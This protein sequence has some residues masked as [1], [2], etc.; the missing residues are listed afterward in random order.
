MCLHRK[1][2]SFCYLTTLLTTNYMTIP[3]LYNKFLECK[4]ISTDTRKV[5]GGELFFALKGPN[6]NANKFAEQAIEKG[7][8]YAVIDDADFAKSEQYI[9]VED[10]LM[11]LQQLANH[12]RKQFD[13]PVIAITGSNGK[14]TSKELMKAV[15]ESKYETH[16]TSGNF[17]N[18][19]GLP[20]TLVGNG[21]IHPNCHFGNGRQ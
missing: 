5:E 21:K 7:A 2:F 16:A 3:E 4:S 17:N 14:T 20:L 15:L 12:H 8:K 9:L 18:H 11:A 13:I 1:F 19:I 10:A 6:F